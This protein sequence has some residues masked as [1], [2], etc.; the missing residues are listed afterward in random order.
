M[1]II[2][3]SAEK[4]YDGTALICKEFKYEYEG[5]A[6]FND[7]IR[8]AINGSQVEIGYSENVVTA[9]KI[10]DSNGK[11]VTDNYYV[12]TYNGLLTVTY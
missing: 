9:V 1:I 12:I 3:G 8:V 7:T 5:A 2:A 10:I 4:R 6:E 11:D